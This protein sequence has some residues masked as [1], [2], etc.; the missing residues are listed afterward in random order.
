MPKL[1]DEQQRLK[2]FIEDNFDFR[3]LK[4][5]GFFDKE[6]KKTDYEKIAARVCTFFGYSSIYD[7]GMPIFHKI[8][9]TTCIA[10][11]IADTVNN[12]GE[13]KS[14]GAF[15]ILTVETEF[16]CPICECGQDAREHTKYNNAKY[17]VVT[18]KCKGCKRKLQLQTDL[19]GKL[20]VE[21]IS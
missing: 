8:I 15:I 19:G 16:A 17:P 9:S 10:G 2:D 5:V 18:I 11:K 20:N 3:T 21:E 14:G 6:M 7:Y 1:S 4:K 12:Q 13:L